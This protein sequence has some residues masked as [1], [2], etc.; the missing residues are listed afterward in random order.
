MPFSDGGYP[1]SVQRPDGRIVTAFYQQVSGQY[2]YEFCVVTWDV[3]QYEKLYRYSADPAKAPGGKAPFPGVDRAVRSPLEP[4][5][6]TMEPTRKVVYKTVGARRLELHV[7][8]PQGHRTTDRR[9][10]YMTFHGGGWQGRTPRY[11]DPF[12]GHFAG[13][14]MVG[15]SVEYRLLSEREGTGVADCVRDARTAVR[16]VRSHASDLG[17]DPSRIVVSGGSAGGHLAAG[18]ALFDGLDEAGEDALA[19]CR[20]DLLILYYPVVDTSPEGY[21]NAKIGERWRELSP[22]DRVRPN[23]PPALLLHGTADSVTPFAGARRFQERMKAARNECELIAFEG[24]RHGYF[25]FDLELFA[26]AMAQS[27]AF[28]RKHGMIPEKHGVTPTL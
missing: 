2:H 5:A 7:F 10:A 21:G 6:E 20:P 11:F 1:S 12:A 8:E 24:G 4:L 14:G 28:L 3:D 27:E 23:L 19:S 15:I 26:R 17:I 13:L 9:P 25:L 16:Y 18:T 22:V